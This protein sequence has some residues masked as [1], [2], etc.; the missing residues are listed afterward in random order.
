MRAS[1]LSPLSLS[2]V[3]L[4]MR[5]INSVFLK[6][7]KKKEKQT[8]T[9]PPWKIGF[10]IK[11]DEAF[12]SPRGAPFFSISKSG[13]PWRIKTSWKVMA[14]VAEAKA[15]AHPLLEWIVNGFVGADRLCC[16]CCCVVTRAIYTGSKYPRSPWRATRVRGLIREDKSSDSKD[17]QRRE[18]CC[19]CIPLNYESRLIFAMINAMSG[20]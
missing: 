5:V 3:F 20:R 16:C 8:R 13:K 6:R 14:W 10:L 17:R 19:S 2:L 7:E 18:N 12:D 4:A 11:N 1:Q 15:R 9:N